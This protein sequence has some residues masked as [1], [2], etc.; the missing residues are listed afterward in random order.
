[1]NPLRLFSSEALMRELA[2]RGEPFNLLL[3]SGAQAQLRFRLP[4]EVDT[5]PLRWSED[6]P[7]P[8]SPYSDDGFVA[9]PGQVSVEDVIEQA[10]LRRRRQRQTKESDA[11]SEHD[12]DERRDK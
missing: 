10:E 9:E 8:A 5:P 2:R 7:Q 6:N 11:S 3:D 1:M 4:V 12:R